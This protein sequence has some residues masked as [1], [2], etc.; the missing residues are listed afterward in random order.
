MGPVA[1]TT[2]LV[3]LTIGDAGEELPQ[4]QNLSTS[5]CDAVRLED[6]V[7]AFNRGEG[8]MAVLAPWGENIRTEAKAD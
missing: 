7:V 2:F 4:A 8:V 6:L 1:E 3:S 5:R